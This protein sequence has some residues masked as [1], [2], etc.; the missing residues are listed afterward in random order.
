MKLGSVGEFGL[1]DRIQ[2]VLGDQRHGFPLGIGDDAAVL[3]AQGDREIVVASDAMVEGVHFDR[4]YFSLEDLGWKS[5]AV[6]LS[7]LAAMA[8][9]P[10][11]AL[12]SIALPDTWTVSDVD[13]VYSGLRECSET[14]GCPVIGGDTTRSLSG[15][16]IAVFVIGALK[17]GSAIIRSGARAGDLIYV[18]G[19]LGGARTGFEVLSSAGRKQDYPESMRRFLRP[20]PRLNQAGRLKDL[21]VITAMIDISD[22]LGSDITRLCEQSGLG[23]TLFADQFPI[24]SECKRWSAEKRKNPQDFVMESGEEYELLFTLDPEMACDLDKKSGTEDIQVTKIGEMTESPGDRRL[25]IGKKN[26][27][28]GDMG[29]NHFRP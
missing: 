16:C 22:G 13:A 14:F 11:A 8:A 9:E 6:N 28:I 7:D 25:V 1:I 26:R 10:L 12:V 23:C 27:P 21:S 19:E 3:P 24:S 29:W 17:K 5:L 15:C 20:D 18:T 4:N 2:N